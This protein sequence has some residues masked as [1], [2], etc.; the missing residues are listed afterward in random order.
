MNYVFQ[1]DDGL[2][3][4]CHSL[5]KKSMNAGKKIAV[6]PPYLPPLS[7]LDYGN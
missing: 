3:A 5:A 1:Q 4:C 2:R 6:L 7:S